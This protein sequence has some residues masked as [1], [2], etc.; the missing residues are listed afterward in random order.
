MTRRLHSVCFTPAICLLTGLVLAEAPILFEDVTAKAGLAKQLEGWE[1]GHAAAWGDAD[2]NGRPDLYLGSYAER[3]PFTGNDALVPNFLFLNKSSGFV[4]SGEKVVR[5]QGKLARTSTSLFADFD[6]DADLDLL[7]VTHARGPGLHP[8][9]LLENT[10]G[11]KFRTTGSEDTDW[12][13]PMEFRN[14]SALDLDDDGLLD[15]I[16]N[17]GSYKNW[18]S[19]TG[20]LTLLRN[21]GKLT[22]EDVSGKYGFP[23]TATA[24]LGLALGDVNEDGRLDIFVADSNRLFV[25]VGG[26][27]YRECESG[28]FVKPTGHDIHTCGAAFGDLNGDG[29][30]DMVTTEHGEPAR[31]HVYFH[32]GIQNGQPRFLDV[33]ADAGLAQALP[34]ETL[35]GTRMKTAHVAICDMDNDGLEDLFLSVVYRD[36]TGKLQPL[37]LRNLGVGQKPQFG[38]IPM[39]RLVGYTAPGP[40][41]DYDG[42]GRLDAFLASWSKEPPSLLFRN[43][44]EGG[45]WLNVR[46]RGDGKALNTMGIGATIRLYQ[47]GSLGKKGQLVGRRDVSIGN[48]YSS[49]EEPVAHF[50]LGQNTQC[51]IV[52][53]WRGQRKTA[54]AVG[55][56]QTIEIAFP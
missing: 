46:I 49:C 34:I 55:A 54:E 52:V 8:S 43:V 20:K 42:D 47:A 10:G 17:D 29:L 37:V 39:D 36:Q 15:I 30:L 26:N 3:P 56:D 51:D 44:T 50:G 22:F 31:I 5:L 41:A 23:Q 11:G 13:P 38:R 35:L 1:F 2:G 21:K 12:P 7:I 28:R 18:S 53:T 45:H 27:Q 14:A 33:S 16:L 4:L 25:S 32:Q 9:V 6:N 19:G 24:G 48:G 40:V